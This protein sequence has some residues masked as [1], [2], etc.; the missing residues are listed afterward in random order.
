MTRLL[1]VVVAALAACRPRGL[2]LTAEIPT[3]TVA[4]VDFEIENQHRVVMRG[5]ETRVKVRGTTRV[6]FVA[7]GAPGEDALSVRETYGRL[8]VEGRL[9][10]EDYRWVSDEGAPPE[11]AA[12]F[13]PLPGRVRDVTLAASPPAEPPPG[14]AFDADVEQILEVLWYAPVGPVEVGA[15]WH[16]PIAPAE[17]GRPRFRVWTLTAVDSAAATIE[18]VDRTGDPVTGELPPVVS[19]T[20][21]EVQ[22][23]VAT[24]RVTRVR[25][26]DLH[27]MVIG[28]D[29]TAT[30]TWTPPGG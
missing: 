9:A 25:T 21:S 8:E 10:G 19:Q 24:G 12:V 22:F 30:I 26:R 23:D 14:T 4:A 13:A 11:P 1:F 29:I 28:H 27:R 5:L 6:E 16:R 7:G 3:G 17:D 20:R 18:S 15:T 2:D